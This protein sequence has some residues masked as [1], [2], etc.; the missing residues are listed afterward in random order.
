MRQISKEWENNSNIF[1]EE[2]YKQII[3][4]KILFRETDRIVKTS[5]WFNSYKANIVAYTLS[6]LLDIIKDNIK[7]NQ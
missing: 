6:K 2:F 1:N 3:C 4:Y 5:D 7:V